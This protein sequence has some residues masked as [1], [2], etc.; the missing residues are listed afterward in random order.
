[1]I[2]FSD[3]KRHLKNKVKNKEFAIMNY[4]KDVAIAFKKVFVFFGITF[5]CIISFVIANSPSFVFTIYA[6]PSNINYTSIPLTDK[7]PSFLEAYWTDNSQSTTS[8]SN[9]NNG[10]KVVREEVGPAEGASSLAVVLVN[11]GR[12][13]ITGLTAYLTLPSGFKSIK[14]ENLVTL[15]N[16]A[17]SSYDSIVKPGESFTLNF[18]VDVLENARVGAYSGSLHLSYS[19]VLETNQLEATITVPFRVTGKVVL[20]AVSMDKSLIA[21]TTNKLKLLL[22]NDGTADANGVTV[23]VKDVTEGTTAAAAGDSIAEVSSSRTPSNSETQTDGN[24]TNDDNTG[25]KGAGQ[26]GDSSPIVNVQAKKFTIGKIPAK[27]SVMINPVVYPSYSSGGSVQNLDMEIVYN[28]A[29]GNRRSTGSSVG[30]V[31]EPN[32]PES[33][34]DISI[35]KIDNNNNDRILS[36]DT[37][38]HENTIPATNSNENKITSS[39]QQQQTIS[40]KLPS[41]ISLVAGKI[42]N[43]SLLITNNGNLTLHNLVLSLSSQSDSVKILGKSKWTIKSLNPLS[44]LSVSTM[45]YAGEG[46]IGNPI[47]IKMNAEYISGGQSKTDTANIGLYVEGQIKV[48]LYDLEINDIG[49]TPNLVGNLLN[50]GNTVALFTNIAIANSNNKNNYNNEVNEGESKSAVSGGIESNNTININSS[51]KNNNSKQEKPN[52]FLTQLPPSQYLGDLS[53]NSPLPFSIPLDINKDATKGTYPISV[54]VTYNDNLRN[55]HLLL[56]NGTVRYIPHQTEADT[57]TKGY[58]GLDTQSPSFIIIVIGVF[59]AFVLV[60]AIL[61]KK[62][63]GKVNNKSNDLRL[64]NR[65]SND[66]SED[67]DLFDK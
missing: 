29:Y 31:V 66:N 11:K 15:P 48:R 5:M 47:Q 32:P 27:S 52:Q 2:L 10:N 3:S 34:L 14:G 4:N 38:S 18:I 33:V 19:K 45:I 50:E 49:N 21:G 7:S 16:V 1:M 9:N 53:E 17:V 36:K 26:D 61:R 56:L 8:P 44:H 6:Q 22:K 57:N 46:V 55:T 37:I 64:K 40:P 54:K 43:A 41:S 28:D 60:Y 62:R 51:S 42:E 59:V 58:F 25:Q 63:K 65:F 24:A 23:T 12:S 30:L 67:F 20:D 35:I 39:D 13:D